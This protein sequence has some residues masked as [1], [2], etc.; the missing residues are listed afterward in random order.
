MGVFVGFLTALGVLIILSLIYCFIGR[1]VFVDRMLAQGKC[2]SFFFL[3]LFVF[4]VPLT[5]SGAFYLFNIR[6]ED[7]I[8]ERALDEPN[9]VWTLIYHC[10]DPGNQHMAADGWFRACSCLLAIFGSVFFNGLLISLFVGWYDRL[11]SRWE[12]GLTRYNRVLK[13]G[14][15]VVIVGDN[16]MVPSIIAQ[17]FERRRGLEHVVVQTNRDVPGLRKRLVSFLKSEDEKRVIIYSGEMTSK[18]D[19]R[20]LHTEY[21]REVFI[22]GNSIEDGESAINHDALC[23]DCVRIMA[24]LLKE[25]G[26]PSGKLLCRVMFEYQTTFSIF[27]FADISDNVRDIIDFRPFNYYEMWAQ[28]LFVN[29]KLHFVKEDLNEYLP[30]EGEKPITFDSK[31]TVHLVVV[32][33]SNMGVALAVEAAHLA[34]YP[35]FNADSRLKTRITFIDNDCITQM[36]YFK[37][38]FKELFSLSRFRKVVVKE[39]DNTLYADSKDYSS[40]ENT[41]FFEKNSYLGDDFIDIEW[42]FIQGGIETPQ[43]HAYLRDAAN[44]CSTRFTLALCIPDDNKAVASALY[45]PDEVYQKAV[46]V[47]VYQRHNASVINSISL[48]N[49]VNLYYKQLKAFGML[50]DAYDDYMQMTAHE[51]SSIFDNHYYEMYQRVNAENNIRE[52]SRKNTRGKSRAAKMW[53]CMYNANSVWGKMRSVHYYK[54]NTISEQNIAILAKTEHTRWSMEQL[55]MRF[56]ILTEDEQKSVLDG[57]LD[58][59]ML[60]GDCMAHLDICSYERLAEVDPVVVEYDE[61]FIRLIPDVLKNLPA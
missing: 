38:R 46:Q 2:L 33:M 50:T 10:I 25:T 58:K 56:R 31:D 27:Q 14:N 49:K 60:K 36:G 59:D 42:E 54:N 28:R 52:T 61:G 5:L 9:L 22:L 16:E 43:V 35:N 24:L 57:S 53:S 48:D 41:D 15:F 45:L 12:N 8:S 44:D 55:L 11:V 7:F 40:W 32:G 1:N 37:G 3:M 51:I 26:R 4:I 13:R 47:L 30:L 6:G 39:D 29:R 34:H 21:A 20:D 23:L 17:L 19:I 18:D